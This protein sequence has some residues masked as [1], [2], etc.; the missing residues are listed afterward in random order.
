MKLDGGEIKS[1]GQ[2]HKVESEACD[3]WHFCCLP[4]W[5]FTWLRLTLL[6]WCFWLWVDILV[7]TGHMPF[8]SYLSVS[9]L[10]SP[11]YGC[12][13]P[14]NFKHFRRYHEYCIAPPVNMIG[15]LLLSLSLL[16]LS[17]HLFSLQGWFSGERQGSVLIH[18]ILC[19]VQNNSG[20]VLCFYLRYVLYW[21]LQPTEYKYWVLFCFS[22]I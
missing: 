19:S 17:L 21:T 5:L 4:A 20:I 22:I 14:S 13:C 18:S 10:A 2:S 15:F 6:M 7:F 8:L 3:F 16:C 9:L 12:W 1:F 11:F